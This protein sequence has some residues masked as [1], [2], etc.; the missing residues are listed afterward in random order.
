MKTKLIALAL[1]GGGIVG[2]PAAAEDIAITY[3]DLDLATEK[4]QRILQHRIDKAARK[5]CGYDEQRTGTRIRPWET[6]RCYALAKAD[7][8]RALATLVLKQRLKA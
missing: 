1:I 8:R 5:V 6:D 4:G 2:T 7:G 3:Q